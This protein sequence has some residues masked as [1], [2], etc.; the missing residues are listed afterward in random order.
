[1]MC[2]PAGEFADGMVEDLPAPLSGRGARPAT[3]DAVVAGGAGHAVAFSA[4]AG[5][6]GRSRAMKWPAPWTW[7]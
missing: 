5:T 3:G 1:M 2:P 6:S 7:V 4:A